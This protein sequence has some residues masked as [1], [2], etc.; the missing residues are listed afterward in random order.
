M[1][2]AIGEVIMAV[3]VT[4]VIAQRCD[5]DRRVSNLRPEQ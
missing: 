1:S 3:A 2:K 5:D 4:G